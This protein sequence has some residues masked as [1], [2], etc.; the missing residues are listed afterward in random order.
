MPNTENNYPKG[1]E[2]P[3]QG[4]DDKVGGGNDTPILSFLPLPCHFRLS[5][6]IPAEAGIH[7]IKVEQDFSAVLTY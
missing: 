3:A 7:T 5:L 1:V 6:V 2:I 4:R